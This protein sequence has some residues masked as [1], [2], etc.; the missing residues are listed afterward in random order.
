MGIDKLKTDIGY[1]LRSGTNNCVGGDDHLIS[2]YAQATEDQ[3]AGFWEVLGK[4]VNAIFTSIL[5]GELLTEEMEVKL[6]NATGFIVELDARDKAHPSAEKSF[7]YLTDENSFLAVRFPYSDDFKHV[8]EAV[9]MASHLGL[10]N[11][12]FWEV[13]YNYW[14]DKL[15]ADTSEEAYWIGNAFS[16]AVKRKIQLS[17]LSVPNLTKIFEKSL[18]A[19]E[20]GIPAIEVYSVLVRY[21]RAACPNQEADCGESL[22]GH[23][24]GVF[25]E[26]CSVGEY[27]V[28]NT[29]D[30]QQVIDTWADNPFNLRQP[31]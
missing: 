7:S 16:S 9:S 27:S 6:E 24:L 28:L 19:P 22:K 3:K 15:A 13:Q 1:Y 25:E 26:L 18:G 5:N 14:V 23:V 21:S 10:G 29:G 20:G 8:S 17:G 4:E 2:L 11:A 12:G 31:S 30:M